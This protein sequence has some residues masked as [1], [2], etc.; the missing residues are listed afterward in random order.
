MYGGI[1]AFNDGDIIRCRGVKSLPLFK[2]PREM[3]LGKK[4]QIVEDFAGNDW[5]YNLCHLGATSQSQGY[6]PSG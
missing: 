1:E 6:C 3:A 4:I 5:N 2:A